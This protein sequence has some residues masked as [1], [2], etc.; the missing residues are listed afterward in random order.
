M[1]QSNTYRN[2]NSL[3]NYLSKTFSTVAIGVAIS[4]V[5]AAVASRL[6]PVFM[7]RNPGL[8]LAISIGLIIGELAIAFYFSLNL[9]KMSKST[10][11]FCYI[12]YSVITGL[13]FSTIIMS[14][15]NASVTLAFIST[16]IMFI[17]MSIIGRTSNINFTKVYSLFLP[18]IIAGFI[19]TLL[20]VFLIHSPWIDMMIVY[21]G[22]VLF[23]AITAAD[24]QRLQAFYY[25][26]QNDSE[27]SDKLMIMGAFQLYLDFANLF[28]R[29]LQ[30]FGRRRRD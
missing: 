16:A 6:A 21:I 17:C 9:Q 2:D 18:A 26:S 25:A 22:L 3:K 8:A 30:I 19:M 27:L 13:S 28:I 10:A 12:A 29:I 7:M 5:L 4:A 23:L 14:Y 24:V 20:N 15:A 1:T 11:W